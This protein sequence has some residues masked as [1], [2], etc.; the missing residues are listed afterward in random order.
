MVP[1]VVSFKS[2]EHMMLSRANMDKA[3]C[4]VSK[5]GTGIQTI[6][7][8]IGFEGTEIDAEDVVGTLLNVI[9]CCNMEIPMERMKSFCGEFEGFETW[10]VPLFMKRLESFQTYRSMSFSAVKTTNDELKESIQTVFSPKEERDFERSERFALLAL[11]R[12]CKCKGE[13]Y[14]L[15]FLYEKTDDLEE[16]SDF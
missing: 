13:E 11:A 4:L 5:I 14:P 12:I 2:K 8:E 7:K 6:A 15:S 16:E 10:E 9:Q 3:K 1:S